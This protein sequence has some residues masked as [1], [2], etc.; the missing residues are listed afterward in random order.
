[1]NHPFANDVHLPIEKAKGRGAVFC[2]FCGFTRKKSG[3]DLMALHPEDLYG[4][5]RKAAEF[6]L[7]LR[8]QSA[9]WMDESEDGY[10][11]IFQWRPVVVFGGDLCVF[12]GDKLRPIRHAHLLFNFHF[13]GTARSILID[14]LIESELPAFAKRI[15]G[16]DDEL[17]R[18]VREC[19]ASMIGVP[20]AQS[21][22][23]GAVEVPPAGT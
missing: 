16:E 1:L 20:A 11:R 14:V 5:L 23:P 17:E 21:D 18:R 3:G 19:R 4:S 9:S 13:E 22:S 8:D 15:V 2:Q 6:A 12:Q 7:T 10:C